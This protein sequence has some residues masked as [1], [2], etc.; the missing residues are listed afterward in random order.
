MPFAF[1]KSLV[2]NLEKK[3]IKDFSKS[4]DEYLQNPDHTID[5][6]DFYTK[7]T[8]LMYAASMHWQKAVYLLLQRKANPNIQI[9]SA[10]HFNAFTIAFD[11]Y[12]YNAAQALVN[13]D[14]DIK[15]IRGPNGEV[16]DIEKIATLFWDALRFMQNS[17]PVYKVL[18]GYSD[19]TE[20]ELPEEILEKLSAT[21]YI[22]AKTHNKNL[23]K[24]PEITAEA[25][26]QTLL[27]EEVA[28]LV[29]NYLYSEKL[30]LKS[31]TNFKILFFK[32]SI[33]NQSKKNNRDEIDIQKIH[34]E[35]GVNQTNKRLK[36]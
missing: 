13:Y 8:I 28:T 7:K 32:N 3:N 25:I 19:Y 29:A 15:S 17:L 27:P 36:K 20:G 16:Y 30:L 10:F 33:L 4:L 14:L 22:V 23:I 34:H 9:A 12:D 1:L 6:Q 21:I 35:Q 18:Q 24:H 31:F 11:S 2:E 26:A 5:D